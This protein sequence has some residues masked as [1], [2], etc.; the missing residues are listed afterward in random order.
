MNKTYFIADLHLSDDTSLINQGFFSFL[1]NLKQNANSV[2]ALYILGDFFEAWIGDD[3]HT[4]LNQQVAN[5][6]NQLSQAGVKLYFTHGNRDFLIKREYANACGM[7]LLP[8][9]TVI[10]LYGTPTLVCHGDELCTDDI[11]YQ[12]FRKKSRSWWWQTLMLNLPLSFR[13]KKAAK[14]RAHSNQS[15]KMKSQV[16]MDVNERA[17][18]DMFI[19][20]NVSQMI[21]GHTHR[22]N[23]HKY[24]KN[25]TRYV[26]GDWYTD[27][28]YI[29]A[30]HEG[31]ELIKEPL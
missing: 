29:E 17:V 14:I 21:H 9:Q 3:N 19:K 5:E 11:E 23:V 31:L 20:F 7:T 4:A 30:S 6:L 15:K 2:D 10:D 8:E 12:K 27:L 24:D 28:W 18:S 22:P 1:E 26:L 13:Q 25:K 16:I